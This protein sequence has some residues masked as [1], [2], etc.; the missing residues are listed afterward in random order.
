MWLSVIR[1]N[2]YDLCHTYLRIKLS[3]HKYKFGLKTCII[4]SQKMVEEWKSKL[5]PQKP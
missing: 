3:K 5:I 1:K 2:I 4:K